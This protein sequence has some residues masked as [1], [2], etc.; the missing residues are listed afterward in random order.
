M[1]ASPSRV[2]PVAARA[3]DAADPTFVEIMDRVAQGFEIVAVGLLVAGL[4]WSLVLAGLTWRRSRAGHRAFLALRE[5]FGGTLLLGVEVLVA[6]DLIR[7]IAVEPTL[8]NVA[9]LGLIVVIRTFLSF[10]LE[11]EIEG[12]PPWRR[13]LTSGSTRTARAARRALAGPAERA[14]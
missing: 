13:A 1:I 4:L 7:T 10:S 9:V 14:S 3:T 6:A 8:E 5:S 12:V 2:L 11:V